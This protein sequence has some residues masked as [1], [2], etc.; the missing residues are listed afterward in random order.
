MLTGLTPFVGTH[1]I[2]AH[3]YNASSIN[4]K[5]VWRER[6]AREA[7]QCPATTENQHDHQVR[8]NSHLQL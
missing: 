7:K 4:R 8:D 6:A 3:I 5:R 2:A 1:N